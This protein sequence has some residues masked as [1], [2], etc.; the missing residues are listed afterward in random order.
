MKSSYNTSF[1]IIR[2]FRSVGELDVNAPA[3]I[4]AAYNSGIYD[5]HA[6]LFPCV[7]TS[8]YA[9]A[10][11]IICPSPTEQVMSTLEY[12]D[13]NDISV[14]G[15]SNS[16]DGDDKP[17]I[18]V[19][20]LDIEDEDPA[21]YYDV[22]PLVNQAIISEMLTALETVKVSAGIYTTKTYWTKVMGDALG[23][24]SYP[25]WYPRYDGVDSLDFFTPFAGW[26]E[27]LIKQTGGDV[28]YCGVSQVDSDYMEDLA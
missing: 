11:S 7:S 27:V 17:Q 4:K 3:T 23:Y 10:N 6:Y 16:A 28:G 18:R 9:V 8:S 14:I 5:L 22:D 12:L 20:W 15:Y 26:E 24:S 13:E 25:L 1:G 21:K 2:A 19:I